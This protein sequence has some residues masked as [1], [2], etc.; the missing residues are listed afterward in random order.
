MNRR[1]DRFERIFASLVLVGASLV[2]A[3]GFFLETLPLT[4]GLVPL[5]IALSVLLV[6]LAALLLIA[7]FLLPQKRKTDLALLIV[8]GA[9]GL[10]LVE[11]A[12]WLVDPRQYGRN[13]AAARGLGLPF[14]ERSPIEVIIDLRKEGKRA[15]PLIPAALL[16]AAGRTAGLIPLAGLANVTV[17][18]CNEGGRY[19]VFSSDEH[20]FR[21]PRGLSAVNPAEVVL[22][23]DSLLQ[24]GCVNDD[25]DISTCVRSLYP[26]TLNFA[27]AGNGPLSML[28]GLREYAAPLRP[29]YVLWVY[30]EENDLQELELERKDPLLVRYLE[31]AFMQ[32]LAQKQPEID[33][34]LTRYVDDKVSDLDR[35]I[36]EQRLGV[37]GNLAINA[38]WLFQVRTRLGLTAADLRK[39]EEGNF[40]LF[41]EILAS[42]RKEVASW[43]GTLA[44][45]YLPSWHAFGRPGRA[46]F[47]RERVLD[48]V[49][50]LEIP[51]VDVHAEFAKV[52]DSLSLFPFRL[53]NHYN[54]QGYKLASEA[55]IRFLKQAEAG[56]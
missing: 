30:Y 48:L 23:G 15:Y 18:W 37:A 34:L 13:L 39:P 26:R 11:A 32:G 53:Y 45:V 31:P 21:N 47:G 12:L 4:S 9:V 33:D 22:V 10:Y 56:R 43:G 46:D 28:A 6:I 14:D 8:S 3:S 27:N 50:D 52:K 2:L 35:V 49:K 25:Q 5:G 36:I 51:L 1:F 20:G 16:R 19:A 41:K 42:A 54:E 38:L 17:V 44:F 24:G 29:R 55:I 40:S 7:A